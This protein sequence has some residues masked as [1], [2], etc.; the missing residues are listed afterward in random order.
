MVRYAGDGWRYDEFSVATLGIRV[1]MIPCRR[2]ADF[3]SSERST[4]T[5][6]RRIDHG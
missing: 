3:R 5:V 2:M 6:L 1:V 4:L